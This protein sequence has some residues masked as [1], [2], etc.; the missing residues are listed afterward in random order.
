M[1][2]PASTRA[3]SVSD[4]T[5][6][7]SW[8]MEAFKANLVFMASLTGLSGSFGS[9][10]PPFK[11]IV[12]HH[13]HAFHRTQPDPPRPVR[14]FGVVPFDDDLAVDLNFDVRAAL[15]NTKAMCDVGR[16]CGQARAF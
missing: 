4:A 13:H 6:L 2:Q 9:H 1:A 3:S 15:Q 16:A 10:L 8:S 14:A 11:V 7:R 5:C 12:S